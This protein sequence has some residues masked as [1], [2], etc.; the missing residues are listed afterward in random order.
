MI[1]QKDKNYNIATKISKYITCALTTTYNWSL[2]LMTILIWFVT[3]WVLYSSNNNFDMMVSTNHYIMLFALVSIICG[4]CQRISGMQED[5][6]ELIRIAIMSFFL[7]LLTVI[8]VKIVGIIFWIGIWVI[9]PLN[10]FCFLLNIK[11]L[12]Y[13]SLSITKDSISKQTD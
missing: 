4:M 5:A 9:N 8:T 2:V 6:G 3:S 11:K 10:L 13:V 1:D 12:W 7:S